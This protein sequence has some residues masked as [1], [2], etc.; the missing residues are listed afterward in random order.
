MSEET[1]FLRKIRWEGLTYYRDLPASS[2]SHYDHQ[3]QAST[4]GDTAS[5]REAQEIQALLAYGPVQASVNLVQRWWLFVHRFELPQIIQTGRSVITNADPAAHEDVNVYA[6]VQAYWQRYCV[7]IIENV[8][9]FNRSRDVWHEPIDRSNENAGGTTDTQD[10]NVADGT[11]GAKGKRSRVEDAAS[12]TMTGQKEK[13]EEG[14]GAGNSDVGGDTKSNVDEGD[15]PT[16]AK[17]A[18][19]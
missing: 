5:Q 18:R 7:P 16:D 3:S 12:D 13:E 10:A 11:D 6:A 17:R 8:L 19:R 1:F 4:N 9:Y 15:A 2:S 14:V